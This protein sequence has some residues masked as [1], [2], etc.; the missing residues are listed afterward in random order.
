MSDGSTSVLE[1]D[2]GLGHPH[3]CQAGHRWQHAGPTAV[4]CALPAFDGTG[5]L[6]LVSPQDCAVC[7]GR[8]DVLVREIHTHYCNMCD[9][10][11]DHEGRCLDGIPA[12][13][14]WCF[15]TEGSSK[16][17]AR[18]GPHFHYCP[19]CGTSW[20]H[21]T[22]C[23]AP[24]EA[25][26]PDCSGCF[27]PNERRHAS[28]ARR[29]Y[30]VG[31]PRDLV[32]PLVVTL[33]LAASVLLSVQ[34]VLKGSPAFWTAAPLIV[35]SPR[36]ASPPASTGVAQA[37]TEEP[38]VVLMPPSEPTSPPRREGV[39]VR[40]A[41]EVSS[42]S[43]SRSREARLPPRA[44]GA[45]PTDGR[46]A[47]GSLPA[48]TPGAS[49]P[50]MRASEPFVESP[51]ETTGQLAA[52]PIEAS[53][54]PM[55]TIQVTEPSIPGAPPSGALGGASGWESFPESHPRQID[56]PTRLEHRSRF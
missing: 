47:T 48:A 36:V 4:T 41:R 37:R 21:T 11:W 42:A 29:A 3:R 16:S 6:P 31:K 23:N 25:A 53:P 17:G 24:F 54:L 12:Q 15:P 22:A 45:Q 43:T 26:L 44:T 30:R 27:G 56:R 19:A 34:L 28:P 5:D 14:P 32:R 33:A 9:G 55:V 50:P 39:S 8:D 7:C 2:Q 10:D 40:R 13:C 20:R 18:T 38:T 52:A 51:P 35:E 46:G 49:S 1:R